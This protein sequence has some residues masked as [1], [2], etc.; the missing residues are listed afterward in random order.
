MICGRVLEE[1]EGIYKQDHMLCPTCDLNRKP[2]AEEMSPPARQEE[3]MTGTGM[4]DEEEEEAIGTG[5]ATSSKQATLSSKNVITGEK[6]KK[7]PP[8]T[9]HHKLEK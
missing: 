8:A 3:D 1:D 4:A 2:S 7:L 5:A 9:C 6:W